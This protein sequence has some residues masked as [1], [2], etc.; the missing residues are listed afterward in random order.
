VTPAERLA[1]P[2]AVLSRTDLRDLG[3]GRHDID[4]AF[5]SLPVIVFPGSRRPLIRVAD[6]NLYVEQHTSR[7]G[8]R[9]R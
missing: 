9:V 4:R 3:F 6:F 2:D 1:V 8:G 5:R 7:D